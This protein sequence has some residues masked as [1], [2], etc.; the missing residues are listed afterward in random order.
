MHHQNWL[1][2][3]FLY[4]QMAQTSDIKLQKRR[5]AELMGAKKRICLMA[6][7]QQDQQVKLDHER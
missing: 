5:A 3:I 6:D 2:T 4:W 7:V 1:E